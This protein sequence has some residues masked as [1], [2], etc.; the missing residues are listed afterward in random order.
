M[1]NT[2]I[3]PIIFPLKTQFVNDKNHFIYIMD[4]FIYKRQTFLLT[5]SFLVLF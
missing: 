3:W 5:V 4:R 1:Y 2:G